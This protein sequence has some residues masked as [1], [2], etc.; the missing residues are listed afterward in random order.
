VTNHERFSLTFRHMGGKILETKEIIRLLSNKYPEMKK[1]SMLPND[2]AE[3]N[4]SSCWCAG[5]DKKI[6]NRE[7]RGLYRVRTQI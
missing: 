5:T 1:G 2:H 4:K 7:K 3:G 6:F